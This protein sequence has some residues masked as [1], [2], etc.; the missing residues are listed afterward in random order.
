MFHLFIPPFSLF[1]PSSTHSTPRYSL[2]HLPLPA[3]SSTPPTTH[4][5][6]HAAFRSSYH[7]PPHLPSHPPFSPSSL[8]HSF[9]LPYSSSPHYFFS[10][11]HASFR[12]SRQLMYLLVG[13]FCVVYMVLVYKQLTS[14]V[15]HL[16]SHPD[17]P[18]YVH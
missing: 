15:G 5:L 2:T 7:S 16:I 3:S 13:F 12:M 1:Y 8:I 18:G 6:P 14:R 11:Q 10:H 17:I 4:H 9:P